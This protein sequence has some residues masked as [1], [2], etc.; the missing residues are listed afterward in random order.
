MNKFRLIRNGFPA[1]GVP[2]ESLSRAS[3]RD[4]YEAKFEPPGGARTFA[5]YDVGAAG[6]LCVRRPHVI[7]REDPMFGRRG[8]AKEVIA[9]AKHGYLVLVIA[10]TARKDP[11]GDWQEPLKPK[12]CDRRYWPPGKV[13]FA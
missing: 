12:D 2:R 4:L 5:E 3:F 1:D 9:D 11:R 6:R 8:Y 10:F 7:L 13:E